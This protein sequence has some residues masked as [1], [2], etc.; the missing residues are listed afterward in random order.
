M[1]TTANHYGYVQ[2]GA[3]TTLPPGPRH[4]TDAETPICADTLEVLADDASVC[5]R[6]AEL[7]AA[8]TTSYALVTQPGHH[9]TAGRR[10]WRSIEPHPTLVYTVI[11]RIATGTADAGAVE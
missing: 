7:T 4:A 2:G 3:Q 11:Q 5:A 6:A 1:F 8:G 9:A 10:R